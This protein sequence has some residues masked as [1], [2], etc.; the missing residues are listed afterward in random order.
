MSR[1]GCGGRRWGCARSGRR[2]SAGRVQPPVDRGDLRGRG[3]AEFVTQPVGELVVGLCRLGVLAG[4]DEGVDQV[5]VDGF[6]ERVMRRGTPV[7]LDGR[8]DSA[9]R[10]EQLACRRT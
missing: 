3:D 5:S 1:G 10:D 7:D 8:T 9:R 6:V 4:A 2:R